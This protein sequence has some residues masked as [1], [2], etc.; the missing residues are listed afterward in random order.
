[1]DWV[2]REAAKRAAQQR[3]RPVGYRPPA[4]LSAELD[5]PSRRP[6]NLPPYVP[7]RDEIAL[8]CAML[9]AGWD[10]ETEIS[11]RQ[12]GR[13][14]PAW[15][16]PYVHV[17]LFALDD[18]RNHDAPVGTWDNVVRAYEDNPPVYCALAGGMPAPTYD[19]EAR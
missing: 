10:A 12:G 6:C 7:S 14:P 8:Q 3:L 9:Q 4:K 5:Q 17:D 13:E 18:S 15:E 16:F 19:K 1:M 11:R 2:Y